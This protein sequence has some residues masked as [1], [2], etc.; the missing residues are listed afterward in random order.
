[1]PQVES[2]KAIT[3]KGVGRTDY[4]TNIEASVEPIIRSYQN[5]YKYINTYAIIPGA[6]ETVEV[7]FDP[8]HVLL[9]YDFVASCQ[10]NVLL[11]FC[12]SVGNSEG[13]LED[14]FDKYG[15][16]KV[17]QHQARGAVT[18]VKWNATIKNMSA[19]PITVVLNIVGIWLT[20]QQYLQEI[21]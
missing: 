16:Q 5:S 18:F 8:N 1:M 13:V 21:A 3:A 2:T 15:Y 6:T 4:S 19:L 11:D 9:L 7:I 14:V 20:K 10:K 17:E 12:V